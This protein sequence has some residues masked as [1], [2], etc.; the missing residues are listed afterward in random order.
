MFD[1]LLKLVEE[2]AGDA[3]VNNKSIPNEKNNDAMKE[4]ANSIINSLKK[5]Q[6]SAGSGSDLASMFSGGD[7]SSLTKMVEGNVVGDLMK[8]FGVDNKIAGDMV[9]KMLPGIMQKFV[10]KTNDPNDSSFDL[11][12]IMKYLK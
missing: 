9:G 5:Q 2:H 8:N 3:I 1:Q 7:T 4:T 10:S 12:D 11:G 6:K